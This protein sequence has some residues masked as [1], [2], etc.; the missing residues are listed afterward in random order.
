[1]TEKQIKKETFIDFAHRI[2][3]E[4]NKNEQSRLDNEWKEALQAPDR[5][6]AVRVFA[7]REGYSFTTAE[8]QDALAFWDKF[9]ELN[10]DCETGCPDTAGGPVIY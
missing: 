4:P 7:K 10:P 2:L 9:M 3:F 8:C 5:A 6:R 1:M